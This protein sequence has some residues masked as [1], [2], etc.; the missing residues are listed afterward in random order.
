MLPRAVCAADQPHVFDV[1]MQSSLLAQFAHDP[2]EMNAAVL[3]PDSYYSEPQRRYT[4]LYWLTGPADYHIGQ[5]DEAAL[6]QA[7]A[8]SH[9]QVIVVSLEGTRV[10]MYSEYVDSANDGPFATAFVREFIPEIESQYRVFGTSATRFLGG[11]L[12]GGWSALWLQLNY[13]DVFGGTWSV[14]PGQPE[15]DFQ[16]FFGGPDL[17]KASPGNFYH[18]AQG[19]PYQSEF[20]IATKQCQRSRISVSCSQFSPPK[21]ITIPDLFQRGGGENAMFT[22][23]E[24]LM[25]PRGADAKPQ[26]LFDR[27]TGSIDPSVAQY[28]DTHYDIAYLVRDRWPQFGGQLHGK[29]H[30]FAAEYNQKP[31]LDVLALRDQLQSLGSGAE[32]EISPISD[33]RSPLIEQ[34]GLLTQIFSEIGAA[35]RP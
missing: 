34:S 25:S 28:W 7:M 32:V 10:G 23:R 16:H 21:A 33:P 2:V 20:S 22:S 26:P 18:D 9:T 31:P 15:V 13:P 12:S 5:A 14:S 17:T 35:F 29:L 27:K 6:H 8:Q 19:N 1:S 24:E 30:V 3:L 11:V 4:V